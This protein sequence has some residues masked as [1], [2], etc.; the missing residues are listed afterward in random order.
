MNESSF[1]SLPHD[2]ETESK[3]NTS[4]D[5]FFFALNVDVRKEDR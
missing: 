5:P 4:A 1:K 2:R 3:P